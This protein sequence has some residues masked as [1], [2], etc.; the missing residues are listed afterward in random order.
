MSETR[1]GERVPSRVDRLLSRLRCP[2][3]RRMKPRIDSGML[4]KR[5]WVLDWSSDSGSSVMPLDVISRVD[6]E[7]P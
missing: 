2:D 6:G 1:E 4:E 3:W 7:G 5:R